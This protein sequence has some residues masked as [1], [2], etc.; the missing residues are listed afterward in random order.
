MR[1]SRFLAEEIM[2]SVGSGLQQQFTTMLFGRWGGNVREYPGGRMHRGRTQKTRVSFH[3]LL[4]LA[5]IGLFFVGTAWAGVTGSI[6]GVIRDSSGAVVPGVQVSAHNTETGLQWTTSTDDKGF[7]S[8]QAL[9]VGT[10]DVEAN[11]TG[12][13]GY[14]QSGIV[15]NVNSSIAVDVALQAGGVAESITVTSNAVHVE[16]TSTQMGEVIDS[17]KITEVPLVDRS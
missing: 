16:E 10:Y 15:I 14:K 12:F 17:Q 13:R 11:K 6:S 7:Y 5:S 2:T 1:K 3:F 8:F 4:A 9:P